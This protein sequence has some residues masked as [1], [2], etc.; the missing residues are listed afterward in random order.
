[1]AETQVAE[2]STDK[3]SAGAEKRPLDDLMLAMDVVDT[4]RHRASLVERELHAEERDQQ[5]IE[6]LRE[7]YAAQGIEVPDEVL[8]E[9][10]TALKE[11]RFT[12]TP[13]E[14]SLSLTLA[15]VYVNRRRWIT[16]LAIGLGALCAVWLGYVLLVSAPRKRLLR[17]L[18]RQVA[19]QREAI[20]GQ[21]REGEAKDEA[22]QLASAADRALREGNLTEAQ[23]LLDELKDLRGRLE[24]EYELR[25]VTEGSTGVWRIPD[26]NESARNYYI[27]VEPVTD[28]GEILTLPVTSEEDGKTTSVSK[29][30]LRVDEQTFNQIEADKKDDGIIQ[31]RQFGVKRLGSLEPEYLLPTTGGA[32]TS[33]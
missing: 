1:M 3:T 29:W 16:P 19:A 30:G 13:P 24:Q 9:G 12:Y 4:L 2:K 8:A 31:R 7:I 21:S 26:V 28:G 5:L 11:D 27:I 22:A 18:P 6:R 32:I 10:V 23:R 33:W 14:P 17:E 15:K 25:I 20:V